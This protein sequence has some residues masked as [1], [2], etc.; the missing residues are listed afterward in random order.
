MNKT[1]EDRKEM[2]H[3]GADPLGRWN[4]L[5]IQHFSRPQVMNSGP[6]PYQNKQ[7]FSTV[8]RIKKKTTHNNL[9]I[10]H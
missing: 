7:H 6:T 9:M 2:V 3:A 1:Q 10:F 8:H 5:R 4:A